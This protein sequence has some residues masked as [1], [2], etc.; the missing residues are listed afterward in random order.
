MM[1]FEMQ[2]LLVW[3]RAE[4]KP[5]TG[6]EASPNDLLERLKHYHR[7]AAEVHLSNHRHYMIDWLIYWLTDWVIDW[8]KVENVTDDPLCIEWQYER[9]VKDI[10]Y[11]L[12]T[13]W[14]IDW[15]SDWV[16]FIKYT[17]QAYVHR[18]ATYDFLLTFHSNH[19][20]ISHCFRG[21][22]WFQSK[23][24]NFSHPPRVSWAPLT[25]FP[26]EL[27]IG[28]WSQKTRMTGLPDGQKSL[29]TGLAV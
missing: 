12:L 13:V 20:P 27:G 10:F 4:A 29:K 21:K 3:R 14:L 2:L 6:L 1:Y 18:S 19:G 9:M 17:Q 24:P 7:H 5:D 11:L 26:L 28:A 15:L 25:G 23:I 22:R 8:Q 16:I